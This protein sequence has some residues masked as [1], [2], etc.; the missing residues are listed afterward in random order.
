MKTSHYFVSLL[1]NL[2]D[3]IK[4]GTEVQTR[5]YNSLQLLFDIYIYFREMHS[6]YP[7]K[8]V[9]IISFSR[10]SQNSEKRLL[11]SS[12]L[13]VRLSDRWTDFHYT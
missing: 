7:Q 8:C 5:R 6:R 12:R 3:V 9:H 13:S 11:A 1:K 4:S 2:Q 10:F